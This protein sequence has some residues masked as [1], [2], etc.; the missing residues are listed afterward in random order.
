MH[1]ETK[2][3]YHKHLFASMKI[4]RTNVDNDEFIVAHYKNY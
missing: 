1:M 3:S 4:M 2:P